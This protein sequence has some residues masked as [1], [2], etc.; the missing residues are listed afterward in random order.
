[1]TAFRFFED[2]NSCFKAFVSFPIGLDSFNRPLV[3]R[4]CLLIGLDLWVREG[5][6][7]NGNLRK[8][9][10]AEGVIRVEARKVRMDSCSLVPPEQ[11]I[12][13]LLAILDYIQTAWFRFAILP[14]YQS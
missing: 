5:W 13:G 9:L 7:L 3:L 6:T 4:E 11:Y 1:M 8:D 2:V 10:T 12:V 14:S